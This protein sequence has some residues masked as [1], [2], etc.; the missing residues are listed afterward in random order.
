M[1][2]RAS[3]ILVA[4]AVAVAAFGSTPLADAG[5]RTVQKHPDGPGATQRRPDR[6][7]FMRKSG[8]DPGASGK[9]MRTTGGDPSII[10]I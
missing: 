2:R 3:G 5:L 4:T 1:K 10:A 6:V 9:A 7:G 8:G